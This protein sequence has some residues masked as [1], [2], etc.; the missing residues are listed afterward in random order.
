MPFGYCEQC[1]CERSCTC[2]LTPVFISLVYMPRSGMAGSCGN[3]MF[4]F[5]GNHQNLPRF[6]FPPAM[7]KGSS[8][9][10]SLLT[11]AI[12]PFFFIMAPLMGGGCRVPHCGPS[13]FLKN[14]YC[15]WLLFSQKPA[16]FSPHLISALSLPVSTLL[17]S[18]TSASYFYLILSL[19]FSL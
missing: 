7:H 3:S 6:M 17:S 11:L 18:P 4:N 16:I 19:S 2:I 12:F 8:F 10:T 5:L 13:S 1:C 9:S 14:P 15:F